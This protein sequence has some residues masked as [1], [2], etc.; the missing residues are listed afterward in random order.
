MKS[1]LK[2]RSYLWSAPQIAW[3]RIVR[4][5]LP[6]PG[7]V[8]FT[9]LL[10]GG[11]FWA[12]SAGAIT[13]GAPA[14][15][16]VSTSTIAYQ[17]RL[18]DTAGVPLTGAYNM[19]FR[20]Y[21]AAS[22]GAPLWEEQWTSSNSVQ[23]S[24]GLFN[25]MLG[26][27]TPIA[28]N[29]ITGNSNVFLGITVGTD[30]EMIPRVQLG[31]VPFAT[32]ALTVPDF[33][34]TTAKLATNSVTQVQS[35]SGVTGD[36]TSS[37]SFVDVPGRTVTLTTNGGA[38]L[39]M[40]SGSH[41]PSAATVDGYWRIIRDDS[42]VVAYNTHRFIRQDEW[43]TITLFGVDTPPAGTHTYKLQ[44]RAGLGTIIASEGTYLQNFAVIEFKR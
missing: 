4:W 16:S 27:L 1:Q 41:H 40:F 11:L 25:V 12:Q 13:L 38:V 9:L 18:T 28:Q 7:N 8:L 10:I 23:I 2:I 20:L 33:S 21:A 43:T 24:D 17:G 19:S 37:P 29:V 26:S 31:S 32:Q 6:S 5:L 39:A 36:A 44:W 3:Y 34:V 30:S 15:T 42:V 14:A 35:I 22:G